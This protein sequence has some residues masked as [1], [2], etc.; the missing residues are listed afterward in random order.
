M[1]ISGD[2]D[3]N[4]DVSCSIWLNQKVKDSTLKIY[5]EYGHSRIFNIDII[6]EALAELQ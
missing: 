6:D 5:P 1:I 3:V 2:K 4:V